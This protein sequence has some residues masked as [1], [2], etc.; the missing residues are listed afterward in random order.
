MN[1]KCLSISPTCTSK[2]KVGLAIKY[3]KS[4][5]DHHL[6]GQRPLYYKQ[7]LKSV[8]L[9][10]WEKYNLIGFLE[11]IGKV[12]ILVTWPGPLEQTFHSSFL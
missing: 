10:V 4:A 7:S 3:V 8:G 6:K 1:S 9:P 5:Q 11:Y 2:R 12:A